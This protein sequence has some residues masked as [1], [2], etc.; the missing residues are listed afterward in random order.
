ML[1]KNL[2]KILI[3]NY[4]FDVHGLYIAVTAKSDIM[5]IEFMGKLSDGENVSRVFY[6]PKNLK[7]KYFHI[8]YF[9]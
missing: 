7:L 8:K 5:I 1:N 3:Q 6:E 2:Y 9:A 4:V